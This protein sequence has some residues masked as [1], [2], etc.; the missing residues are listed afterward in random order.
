[1]S[2]PAGSEVFCADG[3]IATRHLSRLSSAWPSQPIDP[4]APGLL[5]GAVQLTHPCGVSTMTPSG[6]NSSGNDWAWPCMD[7]CSA[8]TLPPLPRL[9]PP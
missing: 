4:A 9:A 2:Q 7:C 5:P 1:M 6:G 3:G 8:V